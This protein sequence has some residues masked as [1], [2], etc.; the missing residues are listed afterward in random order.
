M[1]GRTLFLRAEGRVQGGGYRAFAAGEARRRGIRGWV[2]NRDDGAVEA[3]AHG[4]GAALGELIARLRQGPPGAAVTAHDLRSVD[5]G[6]VTEVPD[7][8]VAF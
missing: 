1:S 6:G 3:V 2:V 7:G 4:E 8:G 5:A